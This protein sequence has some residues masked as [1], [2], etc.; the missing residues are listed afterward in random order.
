VALK[1]PSAVDVD[2]LLACE[3][4]EGVYHERVIEWIGGHHP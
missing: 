3:Q 1:P 4:R 2:H